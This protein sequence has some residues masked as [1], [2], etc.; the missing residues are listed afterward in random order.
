MQTRLFDRVT[1]WLETRLQQGFFWQ[2]LI[3]AFL[4]LLIAA[5][6]GVSAWMLTDQF[7]HPGEAIWW[8]FLRL[9]DPG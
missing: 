5:G 8:A 6:G 3:M 2:L 4:L 9:T 7:S 1:F